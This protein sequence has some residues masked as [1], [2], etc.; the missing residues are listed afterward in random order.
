MLKGYYYL[1][2]ITKVFGL[3][4]ELLVYLDTDEPHKY[5]TMESVF[6]NL[7][8]EP[9]PFFI[10]SIKFKS[11]H[12]FIIQFE[13]IDEHN[14]SQYV[15]TL[16]YLPLEML[17]PLSGNKFYY[18]EIKGFRIIDIVHGDLGVCVDVLEYPHQ[19]IFQI[20]HPKGEI[21]VPIAE[22]VIKNVD[23]INKTIHIQAPEGLVEVYIGNQ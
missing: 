20:N 10:Q 4:G 17:P 19:A 9:V 6:F 2:K 15:D 21:L 23:R 16:L 5:K 8:E 1:G 22:D 14:A 18:H 7:N 11:D 3:K 12:Q 13:D